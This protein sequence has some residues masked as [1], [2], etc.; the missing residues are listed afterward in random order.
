MPKDSSRLDLDGD[1]DKIAGDFRKDVEAA[2]KE[3]KA[4]K[5]ADAEKDRRNVIRNKDRRTSLI[6]IAA[7]TVVLILVAFWVVSARQPGSTSAA[8][9][10]PKQ[11]L[12][13]PIATSRSATATGQGTTAPRLRPPTSAGNQQPQRPPNEYETEPM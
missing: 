13:P 7:A 11:Q 12:N 8:Y 5:Q 10:A 1:L 6:I 4:R 3:V 9:T 2:T